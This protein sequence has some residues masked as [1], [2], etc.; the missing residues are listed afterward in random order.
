M[1]TYIH[2]QPEYQPST[3]LVKGLKSQ[4]LQCGRTLIVV[5][6]FS[7]PLID[8]SDLHK[9]LLHIVPQVVNECKNFL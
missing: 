6:T 8:A 3:P 4:H 2:P 9:E 5:A 1:P 7:V